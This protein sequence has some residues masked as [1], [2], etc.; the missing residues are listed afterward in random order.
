MREKMDEQAILTTQPYTISQ[1]QYRQA[2]ELYQHHFTFKKR[3]VTMVILVLLMAD[4]VIA[5]VRH[6]D[7]KIAYVL[8]MLCAALLFLQWYN[9]RK[10]RRSVLDVTRQLVQ[11]THVFC[12]YETG[13][14]F[15]MKSAAAAETAEPDT[16]TEIE[17]AEAVSDT[18][19]PTYL[20]YAAKMQVLE[21]EELFVVCDDRQTFY[22]LPKQAFDSREQ[23]VQVRQ[24]FMDALG[25]NYH[26]KC[27]NSEMEGERR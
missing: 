7:T 27:K 20:A 14:S 8:L 18:V 1:E 11:D 25:K 10:A 26:N 21:Q 22:V 16:D 4:F 12:L 6:P 2:Y 19:P 9:P 5:A 24:Q 23:V 15:S 13:V 17:S 3:M